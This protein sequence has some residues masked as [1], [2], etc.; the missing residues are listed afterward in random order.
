MLKIYMNIIKNV[1]T[2]NVRYV[3]TAI[4]SNSLVF[5]TLVTLTRFNEINR[6]LYYIH[7]YI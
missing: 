5:Q 7:K 6:N 3:S 4:Y 2:I 1:K